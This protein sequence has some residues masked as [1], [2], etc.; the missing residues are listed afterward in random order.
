MIRITRLPAHK[1]SQI[2]PSC[3]AS[4]VSLVG[5]VLGT[6]TGNDVARLV[7]LPMTIS[8]AAAEA[9]RGEIGDAEQAS[10]GLAGARIRADAVA[11]GVLACGS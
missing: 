10:V 8:D 6:V 2:L 9:V 11:T 7:T 1:P 5:N 4:Q 3:C